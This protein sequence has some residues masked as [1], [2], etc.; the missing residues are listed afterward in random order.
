MGKFYFFKFSCHECFEIVTIVT[1]CT[2]CNFELLCFCVVRYAIETS[3][4]DLFY[5]CVLIFIFEFTTLRDT[6]CK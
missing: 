6:I 1:N 2:V 5:S 4:I 3:C